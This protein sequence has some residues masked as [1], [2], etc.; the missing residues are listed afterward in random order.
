MDM[1]SRIVDLI[2]DSGLGM[3]EN[4][5][6]I[7]TTCPTCQQDDKFSI[8]KKNGSCIC[9]RGSCTFGKRSFV[10]WV[11]LT[12]QIDAKEARDKVFGERDEAVEAHKSS[13]R[14]P[15]LRKEDAEDDDVNPL[16]ASLK[17]MKWPE[18]HM[19]PL[20]DPIA[21]PGLAY[22]ETRGVSLE[23]ASKY[24]ICYSRTY[25]RVYFPVT[26]E[27]SCYGYQGRAIDK[28]EDGQRMRN[29]DGFQ[30]E[31][32]VMFADNLLGKDFAIIAEG[33][34][35]SIKF[36]LV[37]AN[38]C[39]MGKVVTK[40]QL[41]IIRGYDI[42]RVYLALDDDADNHEANALVQTSGFE[43][44]RIDVPK[45]CKERCAASG[46]KADFGECTLEEA[47]TAFNNAWPIK[48]NSLIYRP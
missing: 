35:D 29:N 34:F 2:S 8:L 44:Y 33:P 38:I 30:R 20:A 7:Y 24:E 40:K 42:K 47:K 16:F 37:G 21:A 15:G 32:L 17:E 9:Y 14:L 39:T 48:R 31:T 46:K 28:V 25:R 19:V 10:D 4:A 45:S 26:M 18:F 13:L 6:T 23:M 41:D 43:T 3:K 36:D 22:L 12:F 11:M 1:R 5:N 27:G